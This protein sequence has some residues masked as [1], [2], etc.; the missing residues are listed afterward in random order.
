MGW[1]RS[2]SP[3]GVGVGVAVGPGWNG[4]ASERPTAMTRPSAVQRAAPSALA[5][6]PRRFPS[7]HQS[8]PRPVASSAQRPAPVAQLPILPQ[9]QSVVGC[10]ST[11]TGSLAD[12]CPSH[13]PAARL[14]SPQ[15]IWSAR[16]RQV[17]D[18]GADIVRGSQR[19]RSEANSRRNWEGECAAGRARVTLF[20]RSMPDQR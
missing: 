16:H 2:A 1:V 15:D 9:T 19:R 17:G 18:P 13:A 10:R 3:L 4:K 20:G 6:Y 14:S 11:L 12:Q 8:C 7:S 5:L